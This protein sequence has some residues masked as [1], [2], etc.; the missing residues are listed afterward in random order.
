MLSPAPDDQELTELDPVPLSCILHPLTPTVFPCAVWCAFSGGVHPAPHTSFPSALTS[1]PHPAPHHLSTSAVTSR[2]PSLRSAPTAYTPTQTFVIDRAGEMPSGAVSPAL[3]PTPPHAQP[4]APA[5]LRAYGNGSAPGSRAA[6]PASRF[7]AYDE[8][9]DAPRP[10]G[11][12]EPIKVT[13]AKKKGAGSGKEKK[14]RTPKAE[15]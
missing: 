5:P 12:P 2:L 9:A 7:P 8:D 4:H 13:R 3:V 14:K 11:T 6:T 15:S 10:G 1:S